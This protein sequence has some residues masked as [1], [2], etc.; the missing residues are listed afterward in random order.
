MNRATRTAITALAL[1]LAGGAAQALGLYDPAQGSL[2]AAQGWLSFCPPTQCAAQ[3][4]GGVFDFDTLGAGLGTQA[5]LSR[6]D[7]TLDAEGGYRLD[8]RLRVLDESHAGGNRAGFS[9][10]AVG[11][12]PSQALEIGFWRD[13]VWV[14]DLDD[15][16]FVRGASSALDTTAWHDYRL[17]ARDGGFL[18]QA[19]G[20]TLLQGS[21]RD[22]SA[23]GPPYSLRNFLFLGDDTTSAGA[24]V[25]LGAIALSAVPAVPEPA[26]ALLM[27]GGLGLLAEALRRRAS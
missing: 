26:S 20:R 8:F 25:Q 3:L 27:L 19:D 13:Q 18:L 17:T 6:L 24:H 23:F 5:G 22:Y 4:G 15:G 1:G 16:A 21:L 9:L 10:I 2:P 7:Q 12:T 11:S 14:Y